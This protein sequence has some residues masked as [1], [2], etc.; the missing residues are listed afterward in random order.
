M[1]SNLETTAQS[2]EDESVSFYIWRS[3]GEVDLTV[4]GITRC[5]VGSLDI[6]QTKRTNHSAVPMHPAILGVAFELLFLS[7]LT[8]SWRQGRNGRLVKTEDLATTA[9]LVLS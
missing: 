4:K 3:H 2:N 6:K 8:S 1:C 9:T 7:F 5:A